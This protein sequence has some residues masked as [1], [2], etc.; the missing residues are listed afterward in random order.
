MSAATLLA[1][2]STDVGMWQDEGICV[3][4]G[5]DVFFAR[6]GEF[7]RG[8]REDEAKARCVGCP[9]LANCL[10]WALAAGNPSGVWAGGTNTA[11]RLALQ[12]EF[13]LAS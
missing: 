11:E 1:A 12:Q 4:D 10:E 7:D 8:G 5:A 9:V 6:H 3:R 13:R 2:L